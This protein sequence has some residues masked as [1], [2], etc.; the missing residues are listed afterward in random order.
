MHLLQVQLG[1]AEWIFMILGL[2][3]VSFF[4][5]RFYLTVEEIRKDVKM[6]LIKSAQGE[7]K[8]KQLQEDVDDIK[9]TVH[10]QGNLIQKHEFQLSIIKLKT[11]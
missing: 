9:K 5:L 8:I 2:A 11:P 1:T 7:E 3:L 10:E 4:S 6:L